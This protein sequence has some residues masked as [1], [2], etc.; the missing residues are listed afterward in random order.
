MLGNAKLFG[1]ENHRL[2]ALQFS[3]MPASTNPADQS[4]TCLTRVD[5]PAVRALACLG[6][7][8]LGSFRMLSG[9]IQLLASLI[10]R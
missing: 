9:S 8:V 3:T 4:I 5:C 7:Q 2:E 6:V 1:R 10:T